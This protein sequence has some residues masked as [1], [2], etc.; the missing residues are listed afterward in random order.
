MREMKVMRAIGND[1]D[2]PA[3]PASG[4]LAWALVEKKQSCLFLFEVL[5]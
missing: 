5:G 3:A 2:Q 1:L 4:I